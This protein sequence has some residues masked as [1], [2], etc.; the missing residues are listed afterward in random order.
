MHR[1]RPGLGKAC[2]DSIAQS[3]HGVGYVLDMMVM[4]MYMYSIN[5]QLI[6]YFLNYT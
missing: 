4:Y 1:T 5:V 6:K 3:V 2:P